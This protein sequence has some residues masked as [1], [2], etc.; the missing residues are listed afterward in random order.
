VARLRRPTSGQSPS[1]FQKDFPVR[2]PA[3]CQDRVDALRFV[4]LR[5]IPPY[6]QQARKLLV[7]APDPGSCT[8]FFGGVVGYRRRQRDGYSD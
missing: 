7:A 6:K 1:D 2:Q 5:R 4:F 8:P 3:N